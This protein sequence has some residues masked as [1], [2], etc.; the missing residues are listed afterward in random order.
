MN[1]SSCCMHGGPK[2]IGSRSPGA[3]LPAWV[4]R[5]HGSCCRYGG[6]SLQAAG[7]LGPDR[8]VLEPWQ[9]QAWENQAYGQWEFWGLLARCQ[10]PG[11]IGAAAVMGEQSLLAVGALRPACRPRLPEVVQQLLPAQGTKPVGLCIL[12]PWSSRSP[13]SC[14]YRDAGF[15]GVSG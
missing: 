4:T 2:P 12:L 8:L 13:G 11:A 3:C 6:S 14:L 10:L 1:L 7:A 5:S 9:L 15:P